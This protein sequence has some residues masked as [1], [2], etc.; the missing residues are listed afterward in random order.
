M[1]VDL[2]LPIDLN[3]YAP[4]SFWPIQRILCLFIDIAWY[5]LRVVW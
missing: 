1:Q 4:H 5:R 2:I 3:L